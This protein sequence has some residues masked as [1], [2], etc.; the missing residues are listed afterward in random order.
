MERRVT[1]L[2]DVPRLPARELRRL[3][4]LRPGDNEVRAAGTE[5]ELDG[6]SVLALF[7]TAE[8]C[9]DALRASVPVLAAGSEFNEERQFRRRDGS[10]FWCMSSGR[11]LDPER[12]DEG[13]IWVFADVTERRQAE[14][15]ARL[16]ATVLEHIADGVMVI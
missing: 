2:E 4:R 8:D 11:A 13:G 1:Q 12:Q 6:D 5:G 9:E 14:E 15:K 3:G 7:P 16:A 10:L